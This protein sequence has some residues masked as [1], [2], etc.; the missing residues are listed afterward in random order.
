MDDEIRA[1]A[2]AYAKQA[3]AVL[4][5]AVESDRV[6]INTRVA[7]AK[8][9]LDRCFGRPSPAV[10]LHFVDPRSLSD[11]ELERQIAAMRSAGYLSDADFDLDD[12][13]D[14]FDARGI[15]ESACHAQGVSGGSRQVSQVYSEPES[16]TA[17]TERPEALAEASNF[18]SYAQNEVL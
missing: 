1:F 8:E 12:V 17:T 9:L 14:D 10:P 15:E 5:L 4:V 2:R 3:V 7:A 6:A 18:Q 16:N 13:T 11:S